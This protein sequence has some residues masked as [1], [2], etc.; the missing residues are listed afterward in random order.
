MAILRQG[1][2]GLLKDAIVTGDMLVALGPQ[3]RQQI[4]ATHDGGVLPVGL[5]DFCVDS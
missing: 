3:Q 4:N 2:L 5:L 1:I